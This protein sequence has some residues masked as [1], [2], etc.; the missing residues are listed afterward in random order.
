MLRSYKKTLTVALTALALTTASL[1]A[2][3]DAFAGGGGGGGKGGGGGWKGRRRRLGPPSSRLWWSL[4]R[5]RR[6]L[7]GVGARRPGQHLLLILR[8]MERPPGVVHSG[9]CFCVC[10]PEVTQR[11]LAS[12]FWGNGVARASTAK[13]CEGRYIIIAG[14]S[15]SCEHRA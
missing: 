8:L 14:P 7:L 12:L 2:T 5:W 6:H 1:A 11:V 3:S 10:L 4:C 13:L 9:G 15:L